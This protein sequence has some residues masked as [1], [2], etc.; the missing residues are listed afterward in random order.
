MKKF[1]LRRLGVADDPGGA[2]PTLQMCLAAVLEQ[3]DTLVND[4]LAG[5]Q[6]SMAQVH[7]KSLGAEQHAN[8]PAVVAALCAQP[9][10]VRKSFAL[11]LR[12]A[13]IAAS[14]SGLVFEVVLF[15]VMVV[16]RNLRW[17]GLQV[18]YF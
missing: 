11:A 17:G 13:C 1:M 9:D 4:V 5:L 12:A 3:S 16:L 18:L 10:P 8:S 15:I 6:A 7:R 14:C 2:R